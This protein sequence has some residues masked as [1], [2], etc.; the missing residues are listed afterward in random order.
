MMPRLTKIKSTEMFAFEIL[1]TSDL[2][3]EISHVGK[4]IE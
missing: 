1:I 3:Q 2:E 4:L